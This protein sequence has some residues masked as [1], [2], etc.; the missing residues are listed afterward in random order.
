[1]SKTRKPRRSPEIITLFGSWELSRTSAGRQP[2]TITSY[3]LTIRTFL[4]FLREH[5]LPTRAGEIAPE[6]V[7]RFL[8]AKQEGC[9][10]D[11]VCSTTKTTPAD[12]AKHFR[13]LRAFF[14]WCVKEDELALSPMRNVTEPKVPDR[15][16]DVLDNRQIARLLAT[17]A[18]KEFRDLRDEAILRILIDTG[19]RLGSLTGLRYLP[20]DPKD[21]DV[22]LERKKLRIRQKGGEVYLVP[23]GRKAAAALDRYLRARAR[24]LHADLPDLWLAQKGRLTPSG[25]AQMLRRRGEFIGLENLHPHQLRHTFAHAWKQAGGGEEDLMEIGGWKSIQM[26]RRYGRAARQMRAHQAHEQLSPGD[27]F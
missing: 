24:H 8:T 9:E 3:R 19:M 5:Q 26:V 20:E 23:L 27:R 21:N 4:M 12:A 13:N 17:C 25:V 16:P 7:R 11:C 15:P 18:T 2:T 22:L 6:H 1:M 14:N 10:L